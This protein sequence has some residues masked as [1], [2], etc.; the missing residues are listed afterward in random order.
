MYINSKGAGIMK[1]LIVIIIQLIVLLYNGKVSAKQGEYSVHFI[2][3]E[4]EE[5]IL[6]KGEEKSYLI[7]VA[8]EKNSKKVLEYLNKEGVKKIDT[9][10]I[11]HYHDDH[12]GGLKNILEHKVVGKVVLPTHNIEYRNKL[13]S[14]L[15]DKKVKVVYVIKSFVIKDRNINLKT[16]TARREDREIENNNSIVLVGTID[17]IKYAFTADIEKEREKELVKYKEVG[18]CDVLKVSHHGLNTSSTEAFIKSVNPRVMV[19]TCDGSESPEKEVLARLSKCSGVV[20]RSDIQGNII[21]RGNPQNKA[22]EISSN[23]VI[24]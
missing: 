5:C 12:Y 15:E 17:N 4:Q 16:I 23:K 11:T 24:K 22:I 20:F 19:I 18:K 2:D 3:V 21:V 7:D 6:I 14:F 1:K 13:F 9:I 10:V 8:R